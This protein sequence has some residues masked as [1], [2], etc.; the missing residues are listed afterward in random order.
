MDRFCWGPLFTYI[1]AVL[2]KKGTTAIKYVKGSKREWKRKKKE[3]WMP[4]V[5]LWEWGWGE[6]EILSYLSRQLHIVDFY[7]SWQKGMWG[8]LHLAFNDY[9]F[10]NVSH[11]FPFSKPEGGIGI[12]T[13]TTTKHEDTLSVGPP[14]LLGVILYF[15]VQLADLVHL[16]MAANYSITYAEPAGKSQWLRIK[17]SISCLEAAA[18]F[19]R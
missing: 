12:L 19:G 17:T 7:L 18:N 6:D 11:H 13:P 3:K 2:R 14:Y 15:Q 10:V 16:Q 5:R 8:S 9:L 4:V 1:W